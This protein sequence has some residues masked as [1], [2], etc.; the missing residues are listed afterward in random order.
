MSTE[1]VTTHTHTYF[2]GHAKGSVEEMVQAARAAG[3]TTLA[4]T[5]HYPLSPVFDYRDFICMHKEK[6]PAYFQEID[7]AREKYHDIEIIRGTEFD[8]LG[9]YDDRNLTQK[10]LDPFDIVLGSVHFVDGWCMEDVEKVSRWE[11]QDQTDLLWRRYFKA[12][13]EA[14]STNKFQFTIMS[15]PD[16]VKKFG[17][18]PSFDPLP[19]YEDAVTAAAESGRLIELNTS[20]AYKPCKEMYPGLTLLSLFCKAG[21]PCTIGTDAHKPAHIARGIREG[22]KLLYEAGYREITVPTRTRDRRVI[23]LEI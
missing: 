20:G 15:H 1:L 12:W 3:V 21:V 23:P 19:L 2:C 5:E 8:W 11:S 10:D 4:L 22:Y 18:Y 13:C 16:V 14:V 6:V 7:E 17:Y 9:D